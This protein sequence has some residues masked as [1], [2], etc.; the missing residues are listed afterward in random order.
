MTKPELRK[1]KVLGLELD[2]WEFESCTAHVATGDD[3]ATLYDI[4]SKH[5]GLGHAT[6]LLLDMKAYYE[7]KGLKFGGSV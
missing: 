4:R 2:E 7:G 1:I 6:E 5:E 3:W